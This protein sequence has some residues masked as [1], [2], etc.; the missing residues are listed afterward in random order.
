MVEGR[1]DARR[2]V[3]DVRRRDPEV[4]LREVP[5]RAVERGLE[6]GTDRRVITCS[7]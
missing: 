3:V 7:V 5:R 6:L 2:E 1:D 4:G